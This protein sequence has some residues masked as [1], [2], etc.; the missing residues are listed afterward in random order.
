MVSVAL[1]KTSC[2]PRSTRIAPEMPSIRRTYSTFLRLYAAVE[3]LPCGLGEEQHWPL[4]D[5]ALARRT[6]EQLDVLRRLERVR[7]LL[8]ADLLERAG[9]DHLGPAHHSLLARPIVCDRA[10]VDRRE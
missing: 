8:L 1:G 10:E 6:I 3:H 9:N 4:F 5:P 2:S 7:L